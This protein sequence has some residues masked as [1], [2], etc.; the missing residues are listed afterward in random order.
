MRIL[1]AVAVAVLAV[2]S[3]IAPVAAEEPDAQARLVGDLRS[4]GGS[5]PR[6]LTRAAARVYFRAN[7]GVHGAELWATDGTAQGTRLVRDIRPGEAGSG[8]T[9]LTRVG[10]RVFFTAAD[11]VHGRELWVSDGTRAGTHMVKD[12]TKGSAGSGIS[13]I[14][15]GA[16]TAY[17]GLD[18]RQLWRTDGTAMGTGPIRDFLGVDAGTAR[19]MSGRLYFSADNALWKTDGAAA[20]TKRLTPAFWGLD[21][22]T[23]FRKHIYFRAAPPLAP[24]GGVPEL[25]WSDGSRAGTKRLGSMQDPSYLTVLGGRLYFNAR[26]SVIQP[27][28]LYH[29]DGTVSGTVPVS[30]RVRPLWEQVPVAGRL[31][32][33]GASAGQFGSDQ[34]WVS[35]GTADGT[36]LLRNG[37]EKWFVYD[38]GG[39]S[40]AG[41]A[42]R[43][44]FAATP[45]AVVGDQSEATDA[46]VWTSDGTVDGTLEAVDINPDGSAFPREFVKL[47]SSII[48]TA[49]DG[50]HGRELWAVSLQ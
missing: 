6:F 19:W 45:V 14:A 12:L 18:Y 16:G 34:L 7:D 24:Y 17:F 23:V 49:A 13:G 11:G 40:H 3:L 28:R 27:S 47:G 9:L 50:V 10:S 42:G 37:R 8:P 36:T 21:S 48:F 35:D 31:W 43:L 25:W 5:A 2:A 33:P 32:A 46:E 44:W 29:G 39:G 38:W 20:G 41:M 1:S 15:D 22:I 30:P 26:R 4:D